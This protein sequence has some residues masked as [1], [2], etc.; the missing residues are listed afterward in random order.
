MGRVM[1]LAAGWGGGRTALRHILTLAKDERSTS[2]AIAA[3]ALGMAAED[4]ILVTEV[5]HWLD[6][7]SSQAGP[8]LRSTVAR[9]CGTG[10][11]AS[12][13]DLAMRLL[14]RAYRGRAWTTPTSARSPGTSGNP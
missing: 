9:T 7:W 11:G 10:F 4:P 3:H 6:R 5:K 8:Q 12:R 1:G 2:R 14:L 13:L